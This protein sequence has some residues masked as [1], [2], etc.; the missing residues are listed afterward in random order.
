MT[1]EIQVLAWNRHTQVAGL[2]QFMES[3]HPT[4]TQN[5]ITKMNDNITM[6]TTILG[7]M[8]AQIFGQINHKR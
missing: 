5:T 4:S 7:L 8:N 3:Q 2:N 6:G 1:L